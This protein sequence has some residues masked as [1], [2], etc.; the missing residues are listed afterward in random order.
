MSNILQIDHR[1]STAFHLQTLL[2]TAFKGG[3][4]SANAVDIEPV[5]T[6]LP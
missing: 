6:R 1:D 3:G 4:L 5:A 2:L